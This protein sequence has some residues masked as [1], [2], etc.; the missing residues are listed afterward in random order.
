M[1]FE[2]YNLQLI[3]ALKM[4]YIYIYIFF[5]FCR[6]LLQTHIDSVNQIG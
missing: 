2:V 1:F 5:F 3:Y 4:L 6:R